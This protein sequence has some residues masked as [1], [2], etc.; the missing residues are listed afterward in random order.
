MHYYMLSQIHRRAT[1]GIH[2]NPDAV[3]MQT[4]IILTHYCLSRQLP[5][6]ENWKKG[7]APL[8]RNLMLE[9]ALNLADVAYSDTQPLQ[10]LWADAKDEQQDDCR[11]RGWAETREE[12]RDDYRGRGDDFE[13]GR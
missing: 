5:L 12:Q 10:R 8:T 13:R 9:E 11:S 7:Q 4:N 3:R 2:W 1:D 6:P